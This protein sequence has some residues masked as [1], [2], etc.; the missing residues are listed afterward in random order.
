[1]AF[2]IGPRLNAA[3]RVSHANLCVDLFTC[4]SLPEAEAIARELESKNRER[5]RI[6]SDILASA[7]EL[8]ADP[9]WQDTSSIVLAH[10]D[11]HPGVVGIVASRLAEDH[12][13]PAVLLAVSEGVA[14]GSARSVPSLNLFEAIQACSPMLLAYGGHEQA[15]GLTLESSKVDEFREQFDREVA[16]QLDGELCGLLEIDG[17]VDLAGLDLGFVRGLERLAPFGQGNPAPVFA[18]GAVAVAGQPRLLGAQ[19]QHLSFY[20]RQ[21]DFSLRAIGFGMGGIYDK[22][23]QQGDTVCD[24]AFRPKINDFRGIEEVELEL[25]D[26]RLR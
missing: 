15:A 16:R 6:Q 25:R 4:E 26:I 11:W 13:R 12:N 5:R 9:Q 7:N 24:I 8:L 1:V 23:N 20:V 19:G 22:L 10:E 21:G 14:R 17:E 18:C 2:K 3:G